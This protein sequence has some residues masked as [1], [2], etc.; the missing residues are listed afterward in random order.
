MCLLVNVY[1]INSNVE[2]NEDMKLNQM[3]MEQLKV[4]FDTS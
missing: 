2:W 1:P 3:I 4:Q